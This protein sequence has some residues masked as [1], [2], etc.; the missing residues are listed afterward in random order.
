MSR[1]GPDEDTAPLESTSDP[2]LLLAP[3]T[4]QQEAAAEM[5]EFPQLKAERG[6]GSAA[7]PAQA[8]VDDPGWLQSAS[9]ELRSRSKHGGQVWWGA[10]RTFTARQHGRV[11]D[12]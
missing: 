2:G 1:R 4:F 8:A 3:S 6:H 12:R 11:L 9:S 10:K 5:D 7:P